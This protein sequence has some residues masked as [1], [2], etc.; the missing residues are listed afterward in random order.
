[1]FG[2]VI[3]VVNAASLDQIAQYQIRKYVGIA[4]D[5]RSCKAWSMLTV[6][7]ANAISGIK[8]FT[9]SLNPNFTGDKITDI[10]GALASIS[11]V[12]SASLIPAGFA[13]IN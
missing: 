3:S 1:L 11:E 5:A 13:C 8:P 6:T 10:G 2:K 4:L 9:V 12:R 7:I